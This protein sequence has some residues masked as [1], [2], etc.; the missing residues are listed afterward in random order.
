M[1]HRLLI[2]V[3]AAVASLLP[4]QAIGQAA[5]PASQHFERYLAQ[6]CGP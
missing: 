1:R 3:V 2:V 5:L 6:Q 4:R